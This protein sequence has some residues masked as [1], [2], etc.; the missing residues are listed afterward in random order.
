MA[1]TKRA[2]AC[3]R[4]AIA[5]VLALMQSGVAHA[6]KGER[7]EGPDIVVEAPRTVPLDGRRSPFTGATT[8]VVTLKISALYSDL[9]LADPTDAKRLMERLDRVAHDA[10]GELDRLYPLVPDP[11]CVPRAIA[12]A[13]VT[14]NALIAQARAKR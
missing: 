11:Q 10:C 5:I 1:A 13:T 6:Q 9:D 7:V 14:A 4:T 3:V 2:N 12:G 8:L